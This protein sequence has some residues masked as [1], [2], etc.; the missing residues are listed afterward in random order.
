MVLWYWL[1]LPLS[2]RYPSCYVCCTELHQEAQRPVSSQDVGSEEESG[3]K[4]HHHK[5]ASAVYYHTTTHFTR[6]FTGFCMKSLMWP[7]TFF[8]A[9]LTTQETCCDARH[10]SGK[11]LL[12]SIWVYGLARN[13]MLLFQIFGCFWLLWLNSP[14]HSVSDICACTICI[15]VF[16]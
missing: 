4:I 11:Q 12:N 7:Y 10:K 14:F 13:C 8:L 5:V 1:S 2:R 15:C 3:E 9:Y 16:L 6:G